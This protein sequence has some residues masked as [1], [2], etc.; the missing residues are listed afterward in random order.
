MI[1]YTTTLINKVSGLKVKY[2]IRFHLF[3][4]PLV[5]YDY[6]VPD[7]FGVTFTVA[8]ISAGVMMQC[9]NITIEDDTDVECNHD[10][11]VGIDSV[12]PAVSADL[13]SNVAVT[14]NDTVDGKLSI[15]GLLHLANYCSLFALFLHP[16]TRTQTHMCTHT[17]T[18]THVRAHTHTIFP[19]AVSNIVYDFATTNSMVDESDGVVGVRLVISSPSQLFCDI[20]VTIG[21]EDGTAGVLSRTFFFLST[22]PR[23]VQ[24]P[25]YDSTNLIMCTV[26]NGLLQ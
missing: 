17:H 12:S 13:S 6:L 25:I 22:S 9:H 14:I 18:H 10:L 21:T 24:I 20:T 23:E 4:Y 19:H 8:D 3:F 15:I 5:N 16:H 7:P 11:T 1:C 26:K 2:E